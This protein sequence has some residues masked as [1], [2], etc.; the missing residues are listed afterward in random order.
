MAKKRSGPGR[1]ISNAISEAQQRTLKALR[2]YIAKKGF[3]IA[4]LR[5]WDLG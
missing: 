2:E 4:V 3:A 1:P 5:G